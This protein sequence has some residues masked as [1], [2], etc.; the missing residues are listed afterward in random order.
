MTLQQK[1]GQM[2]MVG[3]YGPNIT[4]EGRAFLQAYQPGAVAL[5]GYNVSSAEGIT[6]LINDWQATITGAGGVPLL[7]AIDQE[8]GRINT[9][10]DEPFTQFPVPALVTATGNH[11]LAYQVGAAQSQQLRALGV[12]MN[13]AP[14]A[15]LETNP[16][17]PVIFRRSYGSDP[18]IV[19]PTIAATVQGMQDHGVLATLKH[20]P[21]H[22]DT[23]EDSHLELPVLPYDL[24]AIEALELIPF[25]AGINAGAGAVMIGHLWLPELDPTPN[26]PASLSEVVVRGLL[27]Q[28][29]GYE[30]IIMT[31]ALDMDAIDTRYTISQASVMAIAAG[32][33]LLA[34]GPHAGMQ[35]TRDAI[36]AVVAAVQDGRIPET[37]IDASVTRILRAKH[38]YGVIDWRPLDPAT[39]VSRVQAVDADTVLNDLYRAG[40]T[41]VYDSEQRLPLPRSEQVALVYPFHRQIVRE[42]CQQ[43]NPDVVLSGYSN[44]PQAAEIEQA[45]RVAAGVEHVIVFTQNAIDKPAQAALV[46]ALP[47]EKTVVVAYWSPYDINAFA[48]PP[49]AYLTTYSPGDTG[50]TVACDILFGALPARGKLPMNISEYILAA[51]GAGLPVR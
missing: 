50:L 13:L 11:N 7:V 9:L 14:V 42:A 27:R 51:S 8:G 28:Q 16:D 41:L 24:A 10:E 22:G 21:G 39:T 25:E 37:Q 45:A 23:N 20:F 43:A 48:R 30:G 18:A 44:F 1:V 33:D 15:D 3:L 5:F 38:R 6:R 17:N 46:N 2:F 19:A 32:N 29:M 26:L 12:H 47:P 31:D 36:D 49:A 35:T 34:L 4:A 40:V